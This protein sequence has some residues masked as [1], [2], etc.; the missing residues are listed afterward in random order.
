VLPI[1]PVVGAPI[2]D[3]HTPDGVAPPPYALDYRR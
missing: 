1:G 2:V 3:D